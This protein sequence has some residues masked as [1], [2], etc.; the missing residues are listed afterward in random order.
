[1]NQLVAVVGSAEFAETL[2]R[3]WERGDAVLP[4]DPR[5]PKAALDRL[6]ESMRPTKFI[7]GTGAE[8]PVEGGHP[9][10]DDDALVIPTSG[11][12]GRPKGVVHTH[13]S[14]RASADAANAALEVDPVSDRW[15]CCLPLS[16][17]GGLS[18][19]TRALAS[20]TPVEI[21]TSFDADA[22]ETAA[23]VR[24]ATLTSLVPT[25]LAR[26]DPTWF[27]RIVVGG[28]AP[29]V[30]MPANAVSS[31]GMTETGSAV[32]YDGRPLAGVEIRIIGCQIQVRGR[33]LLRCY[34]DGIDPKDPDGW[35]TTGDVGEF[36][37]D[38]RLVVHGRLG[39]MITTGGEKVWP[40]E[41]ERILA[42]HEAVREVAVTGRCD[43]VWGEIVVALVVPNDPDHPPT[44]DEIR[45]FV[46]SQAPSYTAP[47]QIE[48]VDS[49]PRTA[50]GKIRRAGL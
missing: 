31:Y 26:I 27:R 23:L 12:T 16:H 37:S 41:V 47:K 39:D 15:L 7:D 6:F 45:E 14:I 36:D 25:T 24:G 18:V 4:V 10:G 19:V 2:A 21:H 50:I 9:V 22:V 28:S 42:T 3:T 43:P 35:F 8:G 30:E 48:I 17:V 44:L 34:R 11:S 13:D 33:M 38:G 5:L 32:V 49:I 46:K 20:E 29:F 1:M 40:V